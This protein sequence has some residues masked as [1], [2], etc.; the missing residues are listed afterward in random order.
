MYTTA[1]LFSLAADKN[2]NRE[3]FL[4]NVTLSV[5]DDASDCVDLDA[6][7]RRLAQIWDV[8]HMTMKEIVAASGMTQSAFAKCAGVPL[9]TL[10]GWCGETRECPSYLRFLLAE[11]YKLI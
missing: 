7:K 8:A 1:E 4:S 2:S 5:S 6:E 10:Q 11:H 3:V 9:R